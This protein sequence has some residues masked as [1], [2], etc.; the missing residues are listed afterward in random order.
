MVDNNELFKMVS[1][2]ISVAKQSK[3]D[4]GGFILADDKK[5]L[6]KMSND[7]E[8]RIT[9]LKNAKSD[10]DTFM[11]ESNYALYS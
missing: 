1:D 9:A 7:L 4:N 3:R 8:E 11:G 5:D 10:I 6:V 2:A